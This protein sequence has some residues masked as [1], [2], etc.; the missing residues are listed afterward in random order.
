MSNHVQ[1]HKPAGVPGAGQ[2]DTMPHTE[3]SVSLPSTQGAGPVQ[4]GTVNLPLDGAKVTLWPDD[5]DGLPDWP[6]GVSEP[7]VNFDVEDNTET[8]VWMDGKR[9]RFWTGSD[10]SMY[11]TAGALSRDE[12]H[13]WA[14]LDEDARDEAVDWAH[15]VHRRIEDGAYA[16]KTA[17]TNAPGV[18]EAILAT[19]TGK[20]IEKPQADLSILNGFGTDRAHAEGQRQT[21][22][23]RAQSFHLAGA[24]SELQDRFP[25]IAFFRLRESTS[26]P[27]PEIHD[28]VDCDGDQIP[29]NV[30]AAA[31][32]EVFRGRRIDDFRPRADGQ[33]ISVADAAAYTPTF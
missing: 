5:Y 2:F 4:Y 17:A 8:T 25:D 31:N 20:P 10:G 29:P 33:W 9:M 22:R 12:E 7:V 11:D 32:A 15:A 16:A 6:E 3:S 28:V 23:E 1:P 14:H 21:P 24:T 19:A 27:E 18:H 13:P 26:G 30:V